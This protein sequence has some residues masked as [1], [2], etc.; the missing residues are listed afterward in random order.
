MD[1]AMTKLVLVSSRLEERRNDINNE[2]CSPCCVGVSPPTDA[3]SPTLVA[4]SG[5]TS[6]QAWPDLSHLNGINTI[7]MSSP[8]L[9]SHTEVRGYDQSS[10]WQSYVTVFIVI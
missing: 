7:N 8:H 5:Q 6:H 1:R 9:S 4:V 2:R 10:Q 3:A